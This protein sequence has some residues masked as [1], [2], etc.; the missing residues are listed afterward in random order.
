MPLHTATLTDAQGLLNIND[1]SDTP[2][3]Q[4]FLRLLQNINPTLP[5][6]ANQDLVKAIA[7]W[8]TS[9]LKETASILSHGTA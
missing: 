4:A 5:L 8:I 7:D 2:Y 9:G 6:N 3:Q 1:L